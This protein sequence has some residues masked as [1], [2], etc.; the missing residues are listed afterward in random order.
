MMDESSQRERRWL[1]GSLRAEDQQEQP[2]RYVV[3]FAIVAGETVSLKVR[4]DVVVSVA[5]ARLWVTRAGDEWDYWLK[6]GETLALARGERVWVTGDT[7]P[8]AATAADTE[9]T[10][11][12]YLTR[13]RAR[14][15]WIRQP[16]FAL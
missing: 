6:P 1:S 14:W 8:S 15:K 3:Q 13:R 7:D 9:V 4:R 11:T 5:G 10:I 2:R 12:T 16:A